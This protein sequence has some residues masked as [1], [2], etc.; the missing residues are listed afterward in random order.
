MRNNT[1][2]AQNEH[3]LQLLQVG[4]DCASGLIETLNEERSALEHQNVDALNVTADRKQQLLTRLE[5][6]ETERQALC[7]AGGF[8]HEPDA[9][10]QFLEA[11]RATP[12][13]VSCWHR[14]V[15]LAK[16]C[17]ELNIRNG[18]IINVR[19][20]QIAGTLSVIRG[21]SPDNDTYGQNGRDK[22]SSTRRILAEI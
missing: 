1:T 16:A 2:P 5:A 18:A 4:V 17:S 9:M 22:V 12:K 8:D 6:M 19:R 11:S 14:L 15:D 13:L 20:Q 7:K 10:A 3:L 21:E